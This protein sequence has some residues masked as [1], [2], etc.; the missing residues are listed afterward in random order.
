MST[1]SEA[2]KEIYVHLGV[3]RFGAKHFLGY[4]GEKRLLARRAAGRNAVSR[5]SR[6][7]P[8]MAVVR[9]DLSAGWEYGR[10]WSR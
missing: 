9:A 4:R 8:A 3:A 2:V 7:E 6:G 1:R 10:D 5:T